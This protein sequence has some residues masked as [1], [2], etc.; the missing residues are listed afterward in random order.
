MIVKP[1]KYFGI[2]RSAWGQ[3]VVCHLLAAVFAVPQPLIFV[4]T[5]ELQSSLN[6]TDEAV[7]HKCESKGYT[8]EWQRKC[9]FTFLTVYLLLIPTGIMSFCYANITRVVWM[10]DGGPDIDQ[11]RVHFVTARRSQEASDHVDVVIPTS[12]QHSY[13]T[14]AG[15]C[16]PATLRIVIND[17]T[18]GSQ[19]AK[20]NCPRVETQRHQDV[21]VSH[22]RIHSLPDTLLRHLSDPHLLRLSVRN[23]RCPDS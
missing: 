14:A 12:Q 10:R 15:H 21:H 4:Q 7:I 6:G 9:Y 8:A 18:P 2:A 19:S 3:V 22:H 20:E 11:P 13:L 16:R 5:D 17:F 1:F 23:V